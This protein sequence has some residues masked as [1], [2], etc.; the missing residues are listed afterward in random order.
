MQTT[1]EVF[2]SHLA[3]RLAGEIEDDIKENYAED[4]I[5]LT[6]TGVFEGHDGIRKSANELQHYLGTAPFTYNHT[7]IRGPYA[8]LEWTAKKDDKAVYDGADS[9]V[10][11]EGK[12]VLQTIH[13]TISAP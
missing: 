13:Y 3:K 10:I 6:G 7:L 9:F 12:I 11:Q 1:T 2:E 4:V 8:F 5:L